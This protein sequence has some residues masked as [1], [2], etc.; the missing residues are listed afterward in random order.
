M[1]DYHDHEWGRPVHDERHLFEMLTLEGAQAGLTWRTIL[2]KRQGY[3]IAFADWDIE[4]IARF[5]PARI[6]KLLANPDIVRNRLKVHSTVT[7]A[8]AALAIIKQ[9]GSLDAYLW[10]LAGGKTTINRFRTMADLPARTDVSDAMSKQL[11]RDG[12]RF[13]G[14]TICYAFMQ[15]TGMVNDHLLTC[16]AH[17]PCT[18][19][20]QT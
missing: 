11:K 19:L 5:T 9:H 13:V 16:P 7:N 17:A 10:Q 3:R 4:K 18:R 2:H 6:E 14:S 12:F 15:A 1:I 8:K 20:S